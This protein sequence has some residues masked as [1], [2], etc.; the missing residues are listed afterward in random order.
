M[1]NTKLV[2]AMLVTL[3]VGAI[4]GCS[5][6][7][8]ARAQLASAGPVERGPA[9]V[10]SAP[11]AAAAPVTSTSS[12]APAT[13]EEPAVAAPASPPRRT[14]PVVRREPVSRAVPQYA[15]VVS[16]VDAVQTVSEPREVCRDEQVVK[17]APVRDEH[18]VAG[19]VAG[20]VAGAVLGNQI[21]DGKGRKIARVVGVLGGAYAGNKIQERMQA[22]DTVTSTERRCETVTE[23]REQPAGYDVTYT[24]A[25]RTETVRMQQ[26]PG[27]TL[28]V[29]NGEV[30][31]G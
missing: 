3:G 4:A 22:S 24:Y 25:G 13:A 19:T 31:T 18:Q 5:D 8:A 16:V 29:R 6:S 7:D 11:P 10:A 14:T 23:T 2:A 17:Q 27:A 1:M 21:G 30:I 20:A 9:L 28:P 15:K 26:R 12:T